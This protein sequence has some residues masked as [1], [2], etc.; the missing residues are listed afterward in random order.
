MDE[1][2]KKEYCEHKELKGHKYT[3]L[4][5]RNNLSTKKQ[6]ALS[7]LITLL[8]TLGEAYRLKLLF[9]DLRPL[10]NP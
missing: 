9:N 10:H 8:P 1:V 2:R 3:F 6:Q 4:K 7:E 5:N